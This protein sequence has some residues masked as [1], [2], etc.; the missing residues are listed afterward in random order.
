MPG[1]SDRVLT[2]GDEDIAATIRASVTIIPLPERIIETEDVVGIPA[3]FKY[4]KPFEVGAERQQDFML[5]LGK[6]WADLHAIGPGDAGFQRVPDFRKPALAGRALGSVCPTGDERT[7]PIRFAA[8]E[9]R[10]GRRGFGRNATRVL[11]IQPAIRRGSG[12]NE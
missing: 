5:R 9:C 11:E 7:I 2:V 3:L 10:V 1:C 8:D 12:S 6:A 4:A